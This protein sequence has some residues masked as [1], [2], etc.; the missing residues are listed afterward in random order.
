MQCPVAHARTSQAD[1]SQKPATNS[2]G[3]C[4]F[5]QGQP[6]SV[7][8]AGQAGEEGT[9]AALAAESQ[10]SPEAVAALNA[11]PF[12]YAASQAVKEP[13]AAAARCPMGH[14]QQQDHTADPDAR[15]DAAPAQCPMGF[16]AADGPRMTQFH[17]VICKSLLYDC[18]KLS[19]SCKYC[20]Y[21]VANFQDCPLCGADIT[22]RTAEPEL[23]GAAHLLYAS[24]RVHPLRNGPLHTV[25]PLH[26]L[27]VAWFRCLSLFGLQV[28][29]I[30][31][32]VLMLAHKT[33][34][35]WANQ[36]AN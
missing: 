19:C 18:V 32:S 36:T 16:T 3:R 7:D 28:S 4:P 5:N 8:S 10:E 29:W 1:V 23:Q 12:G 17:C 31:T 26:D 11:W 24:C 22:S 35:T 2:A 25:Q 20:R 13:S 6:Q 33:C 30:S 15:Q 27:L 9:P 34:L 21:C 14:G